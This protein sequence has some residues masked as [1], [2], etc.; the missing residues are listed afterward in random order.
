M[1]FSSL[2]KSR[3]LV[4]CI[5]LVA[6]ATAII[7]WQQRSQERPRI[8]FERLTLDHGP[9]FGPCPVYK[10][11]VER[12]G[13]VTYRASDFHPGPEGK[14]IE[15][16]VIKHGK[17]PAS[18]LNALITAVESS[19]YAELDADYS[20]G[21]TDLPSTDIQVSGG[22]FS[23]RTHV[24]AVPC[25]KD[26]KGD[27]MY[28]DMKSQSPPVPDIFCTVE[29][30]VDVGSCARYWGQDTRP[31]VTNAVPTLPAPPRCKVAP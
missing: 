22:G 21:V 25:K 28:Q 18:S 26:A 10:V 1:S 30:L 3:I 15:T 7:V 20:L 31:F 17:M 27:S 2:S 29:E 6:I 24:Y 5:A 19:E 13:H 16:T 14:L 8:S 12:N 9:C 11:T 23:T 4:I